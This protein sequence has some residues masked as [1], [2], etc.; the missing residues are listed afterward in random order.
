MFCL[1]NEFKITFSIP[2]EKFAGKSRL[3]FTQVAKQKYWTVISHFG[4][5]YG[6]EIF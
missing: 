1:K 4:Q 5:I 6:K 2:P 3:F